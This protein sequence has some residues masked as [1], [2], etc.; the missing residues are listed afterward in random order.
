MTWTM[1]P[2]P[3]RDDPDR[4]PSDSEDDAEGEHLESEDIMEGEEKW[5]RVQEF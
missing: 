1:R 2:I 3:H 5:L 4:E